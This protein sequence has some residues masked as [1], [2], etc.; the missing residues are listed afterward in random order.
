M[1]IELPD[2]TEWRNDGW[3]LHRLDGPAVESKNGTKEWWFNGK[4][5]RI[6]GPAIEYST[7]EKF[8]FKLGM[9]H[10]EIGPAVEWSGGAKWWYEGNH[11]PSEEAWFKALTNEEKLA[12]LFKME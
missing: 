9:R 12:Y 4:R 3:Q 11:Y 5:H 6:G 7:G 10:S 8:W 1:K 2:R